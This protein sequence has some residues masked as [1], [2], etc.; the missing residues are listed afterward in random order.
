VRHFRWLVAGYTVW[1]FGAYLNI[2]ALGLFAFVTT[3]SA[4]H[5]G[6]FMATRMLSGFLTGLFSGAVLARFPAKR[7]MIGADLMLA[8]GLICLV[9]A[10]AAATVPLLYLVA[11]VFGCASTL[12]NVCLRS[13]IPDIVGSD[14]RTRANALL[15]TA[16]SMA[17]VAGMGGAGVVIAW[18]DFTA[19]F[20]LSAG[21]CLISAA[22]LARLPILRD[23]PEPTEQTSGRPGWRDS[24]SAATAVLSATP[25]LLTLIAVRAADGLGSASHVVGLPVYAT[26]I[27]PDEPGLF[28][29]QVWVCWAIGNIAAQQG[30]VRW[31]TRGGRQLTERSMAISAV[32][33]SAAFIAVFAG[34]TSWPLMLV[35]LIAGIADG[36]T[37]TAFLSRLQAAGDDRRGQLFGLVSAAETTSLG[38]GMLISSVLLGQLAPPMVVALLHGFAI[39]TALFLLVRLIRHPV[40]RRPT[41]KAQVPT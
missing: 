4:I 16:R 38:A 25:I 26:Q 19:V 6:L 5:T 15:V 40:D 22:N 18:A 9:I 20:L 37:E 8:A 21:A 2:V 1:A 28:L 3:G 12:Y 32:C 31:A 10:P 24:M 41:E 11:L 17:T 7:I 14:H 30:L 35:A 27:Q 36:Y 34:L 29:S 33:M 13:G 23:L 39:A